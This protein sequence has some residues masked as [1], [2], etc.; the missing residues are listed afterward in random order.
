M[1]VNQL[2]LTAAVRT[3]PFFNIGGFPVS[4]FSD[5][6][7]NGESLLRLIEATCDEHF[8][9]VTAITPE[10]PQGAVDLID[11]L[12]GSDDRWSAGSGAELGAVPLYVCPVDYDILCGG[13]TVTISRDVD[14]V[15]MT[16]FAHTSTHDE[17]NERVTATMAG[18]DFTFRRAEFDALLVR[19]RAEYVELAKSWVR[20]DAQVS[21]ARRS[22]RRA[23]RWLRR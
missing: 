4:E 9:V 3:E 20:P 19:T 1:R 8:D 12:L 14:D 7:V 18:L 17:Y 21:S 10:F 13:I 15:R 16:S 6:T 22:A 5:F 2:G 23:R 11:D